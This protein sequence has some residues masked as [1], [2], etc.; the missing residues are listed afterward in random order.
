MKLK[1]CKFSYEEG[2]YFD[3]GSIIPDW[4]IANRIGLWK[5]YNSKHTVRKLTYYIHN[6]I[7]LNENQIF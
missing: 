7:T 3:D 6:S 5:W 1:Y 4:I 2:C